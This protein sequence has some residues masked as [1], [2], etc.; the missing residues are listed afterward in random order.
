MNKKFS[1]KSW[2]AG[3]LAL[4]MVVT[5]VPTGMLGGVFKVKAAAGD[6]YKI[7]SMSNSGDVKIEITET[8]RDDLAA[9]KLG[10]AVTYVNDGHDAYSDTLA[11][12]DDQSTQAKVQAAFGVDATAGS[13]A[14]AFHA[15]QTD[16]EIYRAAELVVA[17]LKADVAATQTV[18]ETA[19]SAYDAELGMLEYLEAAKSNITNLESNVTETNKALAK[20]INK[21]NNNTALLEDGTAT[22][23]NIATAYAALSTENKQAVQKEHNAYEAA[24]TN[25]ANGLKAVNKSVLGK[26]SGNTST[27]ID[28]FNTAYGT[29]V[30]NTLADIDDSAEIGTYVDAVKGIVDGNSSTLGSKLKAEAEKDVYDE[31]SKLYT[32]A[33][34]EIKAFQKNAGIAEV[35]I[36]LVPTSSA[37]NSDL[38]NNANV[39]LGVKSDVP[40][41]AMGTVKALG[42][43]NDIVAHDDG[44]NAKATIIVSGL[45]PGKAIITVDNKGTG[46]DG[47]PIVST[48]FTVTVTKSYNVS[49]VKDGNGMITDSEENYVDIPE[50]ETIVDDGTPKTPSENGTG[51]SAGVTY[52]IPSDAAYAESERVLLWH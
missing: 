48:Q 20:A 14:G 52:T 37:T 31:Y 23:G 39:V 8:D 22:D 21:I 32:K 36:K 11:F 29:S 7:A 1:L 50:G 25:L 5:S 13:A 45:K 9:T 35:D 3:V 33:Q 30:T 18:Y 16:E 43:A 19:Q 34:E 40:T 46:K 4:L 26:E 2:I 10:E 51:E 47:E 44:Q 15:D 28:A 12:A 49:Y 38:I 41:V 24:K 42:G 6:N 17:Q 27:E